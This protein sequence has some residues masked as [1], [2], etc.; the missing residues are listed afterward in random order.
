MSVLSGCRKSCHGAGRRACRLGPRSAGVC[1]ACLLA[2]LGLGRIEAAAAPATPSP[3]DRAKALVAEES[4]ESDEQA[5]PPRDDSKS[6]AETAGDS[7]LLVTEPPNP[8]EY[9]RI[10]AESPYPPTD[11]PQRL[12]LEQLEAISKLA[13]QVNKAGLRVHPAMLPLFRSMILHYTGGSYKNAPIRFRLHTPEPYQEGKKYPLVVWL[14]GA[15]ES[16]SDNLNQMSLLHAIIPY[17]VGPKKRD[18]FL[19]LP[20]C[21]LTHVP[22]ESARDLFHHHPRRHGRVSPYR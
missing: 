21:P 11:L 15:G 10:V 17:L 13:V 4:D 16:G 1:L 5:A 18:F 22:W 2:L 8:K 20:Q 6:S 14:H 3:L 12:T 7:Q 9:Q 19:L